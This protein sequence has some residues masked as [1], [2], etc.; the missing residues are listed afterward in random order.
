MVSEIQDVKDM[1]RK[2]GLKMVMMSGSGSAVYA[3]SRDLNK[4]K[5]LYK[6]Y[7]KAGFEVYLTKT[8]AQLPTSKLRK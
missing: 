6:K 7:E 2:D 5:A 3:L 1:L 8:L 4:M